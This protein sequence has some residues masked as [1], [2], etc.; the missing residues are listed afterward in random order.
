MIDLC[1]VRGF[2]PQ[3]GSDEW[4]CGQVL[5]TTQDSATIPHNAPHTYHESFSEGM[6]PD[7]AVKLLQ[8]V[9][10][11]SDREQA[12]KI[13]KVL[14][15]QPL[16]LAAAAYYVQTVVTSGSPNYSWRE[17]Q[18]K[19]TQS[20]REATEKL[21]ASESSA[22]PKTTMAAV[23]MAIQRA[24]ETDQ[25]LYRTF[26]FFALCAHEVLPLEA[27]MKFV[28]ARISDQ[29][30]EL[31]K[32]KIVRSSLI[33]VTAEEGVERIYLRLHNIV[34]SVVK[35][36]AICDLESKEND[37]NIAEAVKIFQSL[38]KLNEENHALLKELIPHCKSVL[39]CATSHFTLPESEFIKKLMPFIALNE[40]FDWLGSL[41]FVC[42][43]FFDLSFAKDVV[44]FAC[45]VL[46]NIQDTF[47]AFILIKA[48]ILNVK[49][50]IYC[51]KGNHNQA[52][53]FHMKALMI[54]KKILGEEH[55]REAESYNDLAVLHLHT[56]EYYQA[57]ELQEKALM[58]QKKIYGEEN[59]RVAKSYNNLA[60]VHYTTGEYNQAKEL[61][62]KAL[63]I[64]KKILGEESAQ[65]AR[66]Y[67]N[68]ASV[69]YKIR[70]YNQ[71][72][73]LHK[74]A[75]MIQ[76][77]VFGE[78][79]PDTA[80]IY[81]NLAL[82]HYAIRE[83]NQAKEF[84]EKALMIQKTIF[85]DQ[86][87]EVARS[88]NNL[89]TVYHSI[90]E[91][92]QAK[93]LHETALMIQKKILG[94]KHIDTATSY[95]NLASVHC[96]IGEYDEARELHE[97]ALMIR[98][99]ILGEEH[100]DTATSYSNLAEV[101]RN[102]GEYNEAKKLH[103]KAL[104]IRKKILGEEHIDIATRYNN[105]ALVHYNI[106]EYNQA[107]ELYEKALMIRK[108]VLGEEHTDIATNYGNLA[109]VY[110]SIGEH[111][112]AKKLREKARMIRQ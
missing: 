84:H 14:D 53:V 107:K 61:Q 73:E 44:D 83:Y 55:A 93:E 90:E 27:V 106:G 58:I 22:Y 11:I 38:F 82:V 75:L 99:K 19:L 16:A 108:K 100:I 35:Q 74:K 13:A 15:Y 45:S 95:N 33:L 36:G 111:R 2:L 40:V 88:Y 85:G 92:N 21:L 26:S 57:K 54:R 72:K 17:Y 105:L 56:G 97:K 30:E 5:I 49:G 81:N 8:K 48:G 31:I 28:T 6:Q 79:H 77:K 20:Q 62:E 86:H 9:S 96:N 76:K 71:A 46:E 23:K 34:H 3:T 94:E 59:V 52:K 101:H 66:S 98:E 91:Y 1:L 60:S 78:E 65:V 39:E 103:E 64:Q 25:A 87:A 10:Q 4:G 29:P 7:D 69:D 80:T 67:N 51:S 47:G 104:M 102:V 112:Q 50:A 12:G 63:M 89:A 70:E 41:A 68:L 32:T 110:E 37:K 42:H 43:E 24:V 18:G 109:T